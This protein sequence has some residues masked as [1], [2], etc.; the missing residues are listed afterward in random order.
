MS[1]ALPRALPSSVSTRTMRRTVSRPARRRARVAPCSPAPRITTVSIGRAIVARSRG[2][3]RS[4]GGL[5]AP[6]L[7]GRTRPRLALDG[8]RADGGDGVSRAF[9]ERLAHHLDPLPPLPG[10]EAG[11]LVVVHLARVD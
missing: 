4:V 8:H 1:S 3:F 9:V 5:P 6:A 7:A 11:E 2:G 10:R